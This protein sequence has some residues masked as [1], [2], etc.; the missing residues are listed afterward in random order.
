[1]Q[2][3]I[4]ATEFYILVYIFFVCLFWFYKEKILQYFLLEASLA[5]QVGG[6]LLDLDELPA[7]LLTHQTGV[8]QKKG[9]TRLIPSCGQ[10]GFSRVENKAHVAWLMPPNCAALSFCLLQFLFFPCVDCLIAHTRCAGYR[11]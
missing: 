11:V 8:A 9:I 7:A 5:R 6:S 10:T 2:H 4:T 1:M 3:L